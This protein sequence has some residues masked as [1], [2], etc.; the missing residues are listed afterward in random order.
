MEQQ[1]IALVAKPGEV[2]M[3][4]QITRAATGLIE[5]HELVG[6]ISQPAEETEPKEPLNGNHP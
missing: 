6:N 1:G 3:T 2:R 5:T 4:L